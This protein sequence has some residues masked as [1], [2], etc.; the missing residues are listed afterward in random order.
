MVNLTDATGAITK[1]YTYDAFGVEK[2]IDDSDTNA[3]R[4]CGEYYDSESGTIY[5]RARYYDPST[6]RFISRDSYA[7]KNSDPLS[8][9]LYTYC[10]NNPIYFYDQTGHSIWSKIGN[11]AKSGFNWCKKKAGQAFDWG[12]S[13]IKEQTREGNLDL[14][15][16]KTLSASKDTNDIYHIRQ[17]CYQE[18][19][20]YNDFYDKVF[21]KATSLTGTS[22]DRK[23]YNFYVG[24]SEYILWA[25]K[26][27]YINLGAGAELGIYKRKTVFGYETDHWKSQP[28]RAMPMTLRL[29]YA[30]GGGNI[31]S[32]S[33]TDNQWWINGFNANKQNR[34]ATDVVATVTID[35]SNQ[36]DLWE[37]FEKK[38]NDGKH[39]EWEFYD[40]YKARLKW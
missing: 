7:G 12:V 21:A 27:D 8:L 11:A 13:E 10:H 9:N 6:G 19:F 3:F 5:L 20:G 29:D 18:P 38:F 40:D 39:S 14:V 4:Y 30:N 23:K 26:G 34:Q 2:N 31:F 22:M 35:F 24:D 15:L 16:D 32:Y 36:Q 1:S 37:S 25:W 28:E 17:K 33:P